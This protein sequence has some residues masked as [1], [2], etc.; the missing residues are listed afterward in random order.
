MRIL[1]ITKNS[2]RPESATIIGLNK[3]GVSPIVMADLRSPH[4]QR[5]RDAGIPL[6]DIPWTANLT[7]RR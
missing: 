3:A 4:V 2:D 5:I 7:A 6:L 1:Y